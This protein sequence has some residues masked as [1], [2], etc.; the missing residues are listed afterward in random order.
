MNGTRT[1]ADERRESW[2]AERLGAPF[3]PAPGVLVLTASKVRDLGA[4]PRRFALAH[5]LRLDADPDLGPHADEMSLGL[6][7]HHELR[8]RHDDPSVHDADDAVDPM[9]PRS[10]WIGQRV[11]AH[12][13][14]CP[15]YAHVGTVSYVDGECDLQWFRPRRNVLVRGRIDALW[16]HD[17]GT[18]EVRDY[19]SGFVPESIDDDPAALF[20]GLLAL[21]HP[22]ASIP[23][24][25]TRVRVTYEALGSDGG[26][27]V[28]LDV[29]A[30]V[31]QRALGLV[32][33]VDEQIRTE[34]RFAATPSVRAC[35]TC[36]YRRSCPF[37]AA[38]TEP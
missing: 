38:R 15:S 18:L 12:R 20:Y 6:A 30:D 22:L 4:C 34:Q 10:P 21:A 33:R 19:K 14:L 7:L 26:R 11:A 35:G 9:S 3:Q 37:S 23:R 8:M 5:V 13:R 1:T 36:A 28:S 25:V 16:M 31:I 2:A 17:D 29:D 24:R 27:L 32:T